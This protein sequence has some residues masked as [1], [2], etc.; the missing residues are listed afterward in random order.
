MFADL[1]FIGIELYLEQFEKVD[2]FCLQRLKLALLSPIEAH[3]Q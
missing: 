2:F 3:S 1:K